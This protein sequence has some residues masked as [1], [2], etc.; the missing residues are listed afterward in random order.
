MNWN[1]KVKIVSFELLDFPDEWSA[2]HEGEP[3]T[4]YSL[5][6]E[7]GYSSFQLFVNGT[8]NGPDY[9]RAK[10]GFLVSYANRNRFGRTPGASY[11]WDVDGNLIS[12]TI[13]D[14]IGT[15]LI[16]REWSSSGELVKRSH[17][18]ADSTSQGPTP[19]LR[20]PPVVVAQ[21]GRS[22][23]FSASLSFEDLDSSPEGALLLHGEPFTGRSFHGKDD[24]RI[25]IRTIINGF[26]HGPIF[27]WSKEGYLTTQGIRTY[28]HGPVGPWHEW[29]K[30]G[31]LL[32]ETIYDSL[33]NLIL[34]R[35]LDDN[36]N[37]IQQENFS[38]ARLL[39]DPHTG[40]EHAAP[41]L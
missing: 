21:E 26:E 8:A 24:G 3:F 36:C 4:G 39:M 5:E 28:P 37:I 1:S 18:S 32:R 2:G 19:W 9:I 23:D 7:D 17:Y 33:G 11:D 40:E 16:E 14:E 10:T 41:W 29:D 6:E 15:V 27:R 38:P 22:G 25:E 13:K 34:I 20:I 35:E 30:E 31:R 12:E